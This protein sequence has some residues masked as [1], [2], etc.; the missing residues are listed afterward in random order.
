MS[1][2]ETNSQRHL[3]TPVLQVVLLQVHT[4]N[5]KHV[6]GLINDEVNNNAG[7][8]LQ[9]TIKNA[10]NIHLVSH[11]QTV[12]DFLRNRDVELLNGLQN[13]LD[14]HLVVH[15]LRQSR[16]NNL[17]EALSQI[18]LATTWVNLITKN[19]SQLRQQVQSGRKIRDGDISLSGRARQQSLNLLNVTRLSSLDTTLAGEV[20]HRGTDTLAQVTIEIG[21]LRFLIRIVRHCTKHG[22][23]RGRTC[24]VVR[25]TEGQNLTVHALE[26]ALTLTSPADAGVV[27]LL[28]GGKDL[29]VLTHLSRWDRAPQD[30]LVAGVR[31]ISRRA[32]TARV[33]NQK[34]VRHVVWGDTSNLA[35][36]NITSQITRNGRTLRVAQE[37]ELRIRASR[38]VLTDVLSG[39]SHTNLCGLTIGDHLRSPRITIAHDR[40]E[41]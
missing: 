23:R 11:H 33:S 26:T 2:R 13:V 17:L 1:S 29:E 12:H 32:R 3:G 37:H 15:E 19:S 28:A 39:V 6:S 27:N 10:T 14:R 16:N 35:C 5:T 9:N 31:I 24:Q 8:A 30:G 4:L 25:L 21:K 22:V 36:R 38:L 7:S 34:D 18:H 40:P 20:L 41:D